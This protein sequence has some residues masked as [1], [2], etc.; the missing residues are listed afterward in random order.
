VRRSL[1]LKLLAG[2]GVFVPLAL[3]TSEEGRRLI[4]ETLAAEAL[5]GGFI[6][7]VKRRERPRQRSMAD[8]V[9][10]LNMRFAESDPF[11]LLDEPFALFRMSSASSARSRMSC[12]APGATCRSASSTTRTRARTTTSFGSRARWRRS[13]AAGPT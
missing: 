6:Y 1:A 4:P 10:R 13:P 7:L 5:I 9:R 8:E 12:G 2:L 11:G 3:L